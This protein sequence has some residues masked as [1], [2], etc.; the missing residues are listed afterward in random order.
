LSATLTIDLD[1]LAA[2]WRDLAS[3]HSGETA[4]VIKANGYG[5]YAEHVAPKLAAAGCTFFFTAHLSEAMAV[6]PKIPGA[7]LGVLHGIMAGEAAECAAHDIMPVLSSMEQVAL[8]GQEARR[9][10]R[11]LPALLHLDTGMAR[12]GLSEPEALHLAQAPGEL[13]GIDVRYVMT[14]LVSAESPEDPLNARQSAKFRRLR[15]LFPAARTSFANSSGLFL[16]ADF[17]S[18][19][20]RPGA[21]IYG[22]NPTPAAKNPMRPVITLS[23]PVLRITEIGPG[24]TVG[25]NAVWAAARPS[26]IAVLPVG[27][28]DGY[29]RALSQSATARFDGL[30]VPLVGRVSMDL[31]TFDVTDFPQISPGDVLDLIGPGHD[32]DALA[33]EAGTNGY[34]ILTSLGR[35]YRR[36]YKGSVLPA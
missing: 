10:G 2:N 20:A 27:Y 12:L 25:Y 8:W 31:S 26:R 9:L 18:D 32:A 16:G 1:A 35:R 29:L 3:S 33:L 23:A 22:I 6:R 21:A 28:A 11:V 34:E 4:A 19:L 5:L 14:H 24:D 17:G 13:A 7:R 36:V 30:A 15:A